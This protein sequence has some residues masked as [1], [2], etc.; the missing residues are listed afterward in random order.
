VLSTGIA[1]KYCFKQRD[2]SFGYGYIRFLIKFTYSCLTW[3]FVCLE[4]SS[5]DTSCAGS[6]GLSS[7]YEQHAFTLVHDENAST[8]FRILVDWL[9]ALLAVSTCPLLNPA[10]R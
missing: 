1:Y 3:W 6:W 5:G 10:Y 7:L 2:I 4:V 8:W 9:F